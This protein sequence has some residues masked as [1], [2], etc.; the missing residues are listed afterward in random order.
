MDSPGRAVCLGNGTKGASQDA[1]RTFVLAGG[2]QGFALGNQ[3][4]GCPPRNSQ[5]LRRSRDQGD[6][7]LYVISWF[8][9][10]KRLS[11]RTVQGN[12]ERER[13]RERE[14]KETFKTTPQKNTE[15]LG[16]DCPSQLSRPSTSPKYL[17]Y[18]WTGGSHCAASRVTTGRRPTR[19]ETG[20]GLVGLEGRVRSHSQLS[21][22]PAT[23]THQ[24]GV[25]GSRLPY[26]AMGPRTVRSGS[27]AAHSHRAL[28]PS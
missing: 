14:K 22:A 23:V 15:A 9:G 28:V 11:P 24:R 21:T 16:C 27:Q 3:A 10:V 18:R 19:A 1:A 6:G 26:S 2:L 8:R 12:R 17:R 4:L 20:R 25:A 13:E 5:E 7:G